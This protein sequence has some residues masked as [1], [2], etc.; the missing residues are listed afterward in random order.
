MDSSG[1]APD[2]NGAGTYR[3]TQAGNPNVGPSTEVAWLYVTG[4]ASPRVEHWVLST[5]YAWLNPASGS[6][7]STIAVDAT[8]YESLSA[9]MDA[10]WQTGFTYVVHTC[11]ETTWP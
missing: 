7:R 10:K 6:L 5:D 4:A 1:G 3:V 8:Q 2:E 11:V 9:F